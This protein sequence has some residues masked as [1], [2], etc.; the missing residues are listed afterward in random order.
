MVKWHLKETNNFFLLFKRQFQKEKKNQQIQKEKKTK[1][2]QQNDS[3][4][5]G[6]KS[7]TQYNSE[8]FFCFFFLL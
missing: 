1:A 6:D 7:N 2:Q 5:K 3:I 8:M 4:V